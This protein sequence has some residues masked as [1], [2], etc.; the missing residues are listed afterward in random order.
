MEAFAG[1]HSVIV[2]VML[3]NNRNG[4]SSYSISVSFGKVSP[5]PYT[6]V[7]N[8]ATRFLFFTTFCEKETKKGTW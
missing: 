3:Y 8:F 2:N 1:L 5:I 7:T 4:K 6:K